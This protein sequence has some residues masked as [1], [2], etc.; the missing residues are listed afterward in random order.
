MQGTTPPFNC[1]MLNA[2]CGFMEVGL[3]HRTRMVMIVSTNFHRIRSE[4]EQKR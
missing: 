1:G 3:K 4:K 2:D